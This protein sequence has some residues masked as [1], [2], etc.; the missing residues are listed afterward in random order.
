MKAKVNSGASVSLVFYVDGAPIAIT[1]QVTELEP[2]TLM[3]SDSQAGLMQGGRRAMLIVQS[4]REFSKA[5][6]ELDA[7]PTNDGWKLVAKSFGWETVDRRRYPRYSI[8]VPITIRAV[9]ETE[10][11]ARILFING[12]TE[13]VS[14]GGAWVK[15]TESLDGGSLVEVSAEF[16]A[17]NPIRALSLVKWADPDR[18]GLGFGV[19]FL[20]FLGG[21]RYALH[22]YLTQQAA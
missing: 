6:A 22:Q 8:N 3:T 14:I 2:F 21:S 4:G 17:G 7:F 15:T 11:E 12:V 13:D 10:G 19:E 5:E 9:V 20:D 18:N 1:G 16:E